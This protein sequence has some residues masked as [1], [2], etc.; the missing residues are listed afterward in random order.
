M[1]N[2]LYLCA[3]LLGLSSPI[4]AQSMNSY[5]KCMIALSNGDMESVV[6]QASIIKDKV[7]VSFA[8]VEKGKKCLEAAFGGNYAYSSKTLRWV[9]G[10]AAIEAEKALKLEQAKA[11]ISTELRCLTKKIEAI[12]SVYQG[13]EVGVRAKNVSLIKDVTL[14]ACQRLH[15]KNPDTAILNPICHE[16][17]KVSLHP[18][19]DLDEEIELFS[20]LSEERLKVVRRQAVLNLKQEELTGAKSNLQVSG[21]QASLIEVAFQSC[22]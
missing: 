4:H 20:R 2:T 7:N 22:E 8:N 3:A 18:E 19:L 13:V 17:F 5:D 11:S 9:S 1:K 14:K 6:T 15:S 16:A 21:G 12:E 10:T